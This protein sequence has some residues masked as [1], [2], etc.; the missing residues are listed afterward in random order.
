MTLC[1]LE[2]L[3]QILARGL[4]LFGDPRP[5]VVSS[6]SFIILTTSFWMSANVSNGMYAILFSM[7]YSSRRRP[8]R[9]NRTSAWRAAGRSETPSPMKTMRGMVP[10]SHS[11]LAWVRGCWTE[12]ALS[13]PR[14][15]SWSQRGFH[16]VPGVFI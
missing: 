5:L 11:S 15:Q 10:S 3:L 1:L 12:R 8:L 4:N 2:I 13:W 9:A 16:S 7:Q 6:S 14:S